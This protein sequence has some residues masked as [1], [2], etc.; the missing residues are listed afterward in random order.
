MNHAAYLIQNERND[1][2]KLYDTKERQ[3]IKA[4]KAME[5]NIQMVQ[6]SFVQMNE[7]RQKFNKTVA[8]LNKKIRELEA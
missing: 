8:E 4:Q 2:L 6:D 7:E 3:I 5:D 1:L